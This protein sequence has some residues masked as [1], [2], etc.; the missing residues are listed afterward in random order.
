VRPHLPRFFLPS[1]A[2][3]G[4]RVELDAEQARHVRVRRLATGERVALFD[5]AG[6]GCEGRLEEVARRRVAV[7]VERLLPDREGESRLDLTLAIAV[8]KSD[9][10][11]RVV[12]KTTELGVTAI[13]P[14]VSRFSLAR[15]SPSRQERWRQIALAAA[16]QC[17]RSVVPGVAAPI[18]WGDLLAREERERLLCWEG[19]GGRS[20]ADIGAATGRPDRM[21]VIVGPEGGFAAEEV[22]AARAAGCRLVDLGPR[23]LRAETAAI[24][25]VALCQEHWG[26]LGKADG[27]AQN[28][29]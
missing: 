22:E 3:P 10:I 26:D 20:L 11:E 12:E 24:T 14:F 7:R 25:A 9:R 1:F 28:G 23:V 8:L 13:L 18:A 5:A 19:D 21:T 15:P 29:G 17:G 16:K 2:A 6:H 27:G 4:Q